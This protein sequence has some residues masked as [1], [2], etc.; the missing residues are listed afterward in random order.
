VLGEPVAK[1]LTLLTN[2]SL[3]LE[4]LPPF[5][6]KARTVVLRKPGKASYET[7]SAWRPIA[8]LKTIGKVI[9]KIIAKRIREA[10]EEKSLLPPSQIGAR[11]GRSTDTALELLTSMVRTI[12]RERKGQVATLLSLDISGAY[13]TVVYERLIAIIKHLGFLS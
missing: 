1:A 9:E 5:L 4:Y 2:T 12:W 10:A 8:L 6:K 3:K 7:V 13:D 11:A